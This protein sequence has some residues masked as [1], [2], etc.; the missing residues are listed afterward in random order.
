MGARTPSTV[1]GALG[2]I[3]SKPE[4][5]GASGT[6]RPSH[7]IASTPLLALLTLDQGAAYVKECV[8]G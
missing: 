7:A 5:G 8:A 3:I 1:E 4:D 6:K 2:Y